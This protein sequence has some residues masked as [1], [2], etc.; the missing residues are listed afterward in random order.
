VRPSRPPGPTASASVRIDTLDA[1]RGIAILAVLFYHYT[2]RW[3]PLYP[4][5]PDLYGYP[6]NIRWFADG[7]LGVEFFFIISGFVI[8]MTLERCATPLEFAFRR[9]V[10]LYPTFIVCMTMTFVTQPFFGISAFGVSVSD[11]AAG[12]SMVSPEFGHAWVDG[13]YWS[14]LVELKFYIWIAIL[15]FAGARWFVP[16]WISFCLIAYFFAHFSAAIASETAAEFLPFFTAGMGFYLQFKN[17]RITAEAATLFLVA[18]LTYAGL[19]WHEWHEGVIV[20]L[21]TGAMIALFELF[22][23]GRLQWLKRTGLAYIGLISYPLYLIHENI[24]VGLIAKLEGMGKAPWPLAV[25]PAAAIAIALGA[26]VHHRV[27]APLHRIFSGWL[28]RRSA[29]ATL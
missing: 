26:I 1:F 7:W 6:H 20:Y 11:Y 22:V 25:V 15:Y 14:L 16:V 4:G 10:R 17:R 5:A 9:F 18:G 23:L 19:W 27:E 8:L 21:L 2:Y 28:H 24:G 13:V 3:G 29:I 12:F